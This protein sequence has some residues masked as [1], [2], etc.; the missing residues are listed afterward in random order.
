MVP[1]AVGGFLSILLW[2]L[3]IKLIPPLF[4]AWL[5][6]TSGIVA[7]VAGAVAT[8]LAMLLAVFVGFGLAQPLSGPALER[9][10]RRAEAKD[11]APAWPSTSL[12]DNIIRSLGSVL[13]SAAF[14]L[15][16]LGLLF[17]ITLL[18]PPAATVTFPLKIVVL[19][20][21]AAWD[22]CDYPLSIRGIPIRP[23]IAFVVRN[24][25]PMIG[26][27]LGLALLS[28]LPCM[29]LLALPAGVAGAARLVLAIERAEAG[30]LGPRRA[31]GG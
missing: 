17:V 25:A 24:A 2:G 19:A 20:L 18:F 14:G 30:P 13:V 6:G 26:F 11:S 23:R 27:G 3:A 1:I 22:C 21:L 31:L 12:K 9:I 28:L 29:L 15:P 5:G 4:T 16:L 8:A 7:A 10:V